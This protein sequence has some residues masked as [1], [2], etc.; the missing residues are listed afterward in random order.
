MSEA[1]SGLFH[2]NP[3][4]VLIE[5][6]AVSV[7]RCTRTGGLSLPRRNG[8]SAG[9][10]EAVS[11]GCVFEGKTENE[12]RSPEIVPSQFPPRAPKEMT[13]A[14]ARAQGSSLGLNVTV[15]PGPHRLVA[16]RSHLA[17]RRCSILIT[18]LILNGECPDRDKPADEV[19]PLPSAITSSGPFVIREWRLLINFSKS[20]QNRT[21]VELRKAAY[22]G[23]HRA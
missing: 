11:W 17:F 5:S 21:A 7:G 23:D 10:T 15:S 3:F 8:P 6:K 22:Y 16:T 19:W 18:V 14:R 20:E 9:S 13:P 1:A 4:L 2:S 12:C